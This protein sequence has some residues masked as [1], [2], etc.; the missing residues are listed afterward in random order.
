[1]Q[2]E[3]PFTGHKNIRSLHEKTIEITK[4]SKLT[5][6][7]DCIIG[8]NSLYACKEIPSQIKKKL[9]KPN[10]KVTFSIIVDE[11]LFQVNGNGH[12]DLKCT[13]PSDIVLRKSNFVCSRTL[14]VNCDKSSNEI[15]RKM[16]RLLQ[17]PKTNGIFKI[18]V[19]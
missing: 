7:G 17:N 5:P 13:H 10:T 19:S 16:V 11:Y 1:M 2:F 8:I 15:P 14:A 4:D 6:S 12:K 9:K 3:I 18:E